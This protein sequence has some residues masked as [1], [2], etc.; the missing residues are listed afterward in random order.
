VGQVLETTNGG[1]PNPQDIRNPNNDKG[2]SSFDQR[3]NS[4]TS[5]VWQLPFGK[6]RK[7]GANM[8]APLEYVLGGWEA[9]S[10]ISLLSG[11]PLNIR[12]GDI[13]GRASDGQPDFLGNVALRP[14]LIDPALGVRAPSSVR[15]FT[16][17]FNTANLAIPPATQTFGNLG[18]NV[19][20]GYPLYQVDFAVQKNIPLPFLTEVSRLQ[21]RGE[22]FNFFNKTNFGAPVVDLR[23]ANFGRVTSTFD[24]R[25]VQLALKLYF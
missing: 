3:F 11:Q 23:S 9:S 15:S 8:A 20:Y 10:V 6:G 18:R 25:I 22:F 19:V 16:N 7:F 17:Y 4:T 13:D 14:N 5:V 21:V 24:P 2:A 1:S 12:Y